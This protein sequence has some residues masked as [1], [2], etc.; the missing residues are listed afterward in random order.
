M[1]SYL[2]KKPFYVARIRMGFDWTV[3]NRQHYSFDN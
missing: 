2:S 3:Y 1:A